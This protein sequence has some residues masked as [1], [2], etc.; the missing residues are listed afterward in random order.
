MKLYGHT[1]NYLF[2]SSGVATYSEAINDHIPTV[3]IQSPKN[4]KAFCDKHINELE[5]G[6]FNKHGLREFL[7]F[8]G[9]DPEHYS[10]DSQKKLIVH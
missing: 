3:C 5:E 6:G 4:G 7:K 1:L 2:F 8:C 9:A 10:K